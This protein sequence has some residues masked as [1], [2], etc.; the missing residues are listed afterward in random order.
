MRNLGDMNDLYNPQDVILLSE[1][2]ENCFQVMND[3]YGFNPRKCNSASSMSRYIEREMSRIILALA[4]KLEHA[5]IFQQTL[6]GGFSSVNI[7]LAFNTQI[8]R[9]N[10]EY[11]NDLEKNP[12]NKILNIKLFIILNLMKRNHRKN[13]LSQKI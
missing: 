5:K 10:L 3:T 1:I 2:I 7:R 4:T 12:L 9:T 8:L 13:K 6:T 11:K